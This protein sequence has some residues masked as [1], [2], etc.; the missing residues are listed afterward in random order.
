MRG[1][2]EKDA[3]INVKCTGKMILMLIS[4]SGNDFIKKAEISGDTA[5]FKAFVKNLNNASGG[6]RGS[7]NIIEP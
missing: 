1:A 2:Q 7:F 3:D 5:R 4:G 6:S